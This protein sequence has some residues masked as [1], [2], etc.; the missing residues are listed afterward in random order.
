MTVSFATTDTAQTTIP[1]AQVIAEGEPRFRIPS[2]PLD[3][4]WGAAADAEA[5]GGVSAEIRTFLDAQLESGDVLLDLAPGFG[6]VALSAATSPAGMPT[7]LVSGVS[8]ERLQALQDAAG[9]AGGWIDP[10]PDDDAN[11]A[12]DLARHVDARLDTNGRLFVHLATAD[13]PS[14]CERLQPLFAQ[15]RV[16]ALCITD[17]EQ[18]EA[19]QR[20]D[21]TL[22]NADFVSCELVE[23][24][25]EALM[26]RVDDGPQSPV[27]ALPAVFAPEAAS[28]SDV[29]FDPVFDSVF[30]GRSSTSEV[31]T[32]AS[33]ITQEL[34]TTSAG[35]LAT[36]DGLSFIAPHSRTGSG[37]T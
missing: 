31:A 28:D 2:A 11:G 13:V 20:A 19:W 16:L 15:G 12:N 3:P 10:L 29:V 21:M 1:S 6:F 36:R 5:A 24:N 17:A 7:V 22:R 4:A 14:I 26:V 30:G 37:V 8:A 32:V 27:I 23:R 9:D 35:W 25:G 18:C 34:S 33:P